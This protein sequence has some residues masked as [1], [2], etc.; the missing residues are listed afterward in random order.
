LVSYNEFLNAVPAVLL[1]A[2]EG[3]RLLQQFL[4]CEILP[5]VSNRDSHAYCNR[6]RSERSDDRILADQMSNFI[7]A[8]S[9]NSVEEEKKEA[10]HR[11]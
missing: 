8:S 3:I 5:S 11:A 7:R 10:E 6:Y 9:R 1:G 4:N 2:V